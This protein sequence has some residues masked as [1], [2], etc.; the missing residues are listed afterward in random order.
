MGEEKVDV[1]DEN[2]RQ[3]G[4]VEGTIIETQSN[5]DHEEEATPKKRKPRSKVKPEA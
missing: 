3:T 1:L 2:G 4:L 5:G